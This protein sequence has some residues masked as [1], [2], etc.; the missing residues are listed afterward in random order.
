MVG[1]RKRAHRTFVQMQTLTS[2]QGSGHYVRL[3]LTPLTV[4]DATTPLE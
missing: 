4:S 2:N 3:S 1:V